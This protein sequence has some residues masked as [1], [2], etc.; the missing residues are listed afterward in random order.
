MIVA[1]LS[2]LMAATVVG[3]ICVTNWLH[4]QELEALYREIGAEDPN[5]RWADLTA[6]VPEPPPDNENAAVQLLR[7]RDLLVKTPFTAPVAPGKKPRMARTMRL[8]ADEA[9]ALRAA[10]AKVAPAAIDEARK[11]KGLPEGRFRFEAGANPLDDT[12]PADLDPRLLPA[13]NLL[14]QD[15][16]LRAHDGDFDAAAESCQALLH[17]A[18]AINDYPT[19]MPQLIRAAGQ[20]LA[21]E[22]IERTLGAGQISEHHLAALQ[23]ALEREADYNAIY[24]ALRGERAWAQL[25]F[26]MIEEG[27]LSYPEL[28]GGPNPSWKA[29]LYAMFPGRDHA[30]QLRMQTELVKASLLPE[31]SRL[32]SLEGVA[33]KELGRPFL[34]P[35]IQ[36]AGYLAGPV[37]DLQVTQAHLRCAAT[38]V[39]VERYRLKNGAWPEDADTLVKAGLLKK[40]LN[41]S[42]DGKPLRWKQTP[43]GIVIHSLAQGNVGFELWRPELR[44]QAPSPPGQK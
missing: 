39:A 26:E 25:Y 31:E 8:P 21:V 28:I 27:K 4:R 22:S 23:R 12:K 40:S 33:Q 36:G 13:M 17:A 2:L 38:A 41:D 15:A 44:G 16:I 1:T 24:P 10:L 11:L 43:T 3:F 9:A 32:K 20:D 37:A 5:W 18:H 30:D 19:L 14:Q 35:H 7:A 42:S 6:A 29:R 34:F